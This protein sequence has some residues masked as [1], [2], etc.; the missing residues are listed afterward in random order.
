[1]EKSQNGNH[2]TPTEVINLRRTWVRCCATCRFRVE[3]AAVG[4]V[5]DMVCRLD[6]THVF[7]MDSESGW[8]CDSWRNHWT[9]S[10]G[11]KA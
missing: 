7:D 2:Q 4:V 9:T 3:G 10:K 8:V 11:T 1:M 5:G 6:H